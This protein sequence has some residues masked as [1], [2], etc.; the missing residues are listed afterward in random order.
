MKS[1]QSLS[2]P[3]CGAPLPADGGSELISCEYCGVSQ[4][5]IDVEKYIEQLRAEVFGWI[6]SMVPVGYQ[7]SASID[8][9]ARSQIFEQTIR[10][11]ISEKLSS[12][13]MQLIKVGSGPL[14]VPPYASVS[15]GFAQAFSVDSKSMLAEAAKFQGLAQFAQSD[16]QTH[17]VDE[18]AS[19][20]A[21]L[22]YLS[23]IAQ[24]SAEVDQ[25]SYRTIAKNFEIAAS[26]LSKD[27]TRSS[28][29][30]RMNGLASIS[31][32]I[33]DLMD[34]KLKEAQTKLLEADAHMNAAST[35]VLRQPAIVSWFPGIK[36]EKTLLEGVKLLTDSIQAAKSYGVGYVEALAA[37]GRYE[38][39]FEWARKKS[40]RTILVSESLDPSSFK[41][42]CGYH[43]AVNRAKAGNLSVKILMG[44]TRIWVACWMVD[45]NYSFETGVLF[46]KKGQAVQERFLVS[47]TF[48]MFPELLTSS[49]ESLVTDVF[50]VHSDFALMDRISGKETALTAGLG[51]RHLTATD[52]TN[53]PYNIPVVPPLCTRIEAEKA[54]NIYLEKA[55]QRLSGKLRVGIPSVTGLVYVGGEITNGRMSVPGLPLPMQPYVGDQGSLLSFAL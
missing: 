39:T 7:G 46:M 19:S 2:C 26:S 35:S 45:L 34:G 12:M 36:A 41:D 15:P 52:M 51:T 20:A 44:T 53:L 49:P 31:Y 47:G 3:K 28:G 25:R 21:V 16:N 27:E 37:F 5:R 33:A 54:A 22:G 48:T 11:N 6:S 29:A 8:P 40:A 14:L 30:E 17:F 4:R 24:L 23:N 1:Y 13:K 32:A 38:R 43:L 9:L 50:A 55:R 42:L 10:G 18:A